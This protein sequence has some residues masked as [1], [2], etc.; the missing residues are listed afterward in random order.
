MSNSHDVF[1][2]VQSASYTRRGALKAF[3]AGIAALSLAACSQSEQSDGADQTQEQAQEEP[4]EDVTVRV[5][6]LKG[7]TTIG[8]VQMMD[9]TSGVPETDEPTTPAETGGITYSYQVIAAPDDLLPKIIQGEVDIACVPSNAGAVLYNKMNKGVRAIDINTLGILSI[10]TGDESIKEFKDLAG[11]TVY[12]SGQGATP[13][14]TFNYLA[15]SAGIADEVTLEFRSEHAEVAA[16]LAADPSAI[17]VLPQ[18]FT[19]AT[20]AK[21]ESLSSPIDLTEVW[22]QYVTDG[23]KYVVGIT[24]V[25]ADFADTHP[26]AVEDFLTRHAASVKKVNEDP[27][28]AAPLVVKAGIVAAESIAA[29]AIP[30]CNIVCETGKEMKDSLEGYLKVLYDAD[31]TSVGGALPEDDFYFGA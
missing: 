5:A 2:R 15:E 13:E 17:G 24:I 23:S 20:L 28:A 21:N 4:V 18:P 27:A 11:H 31:Q 8:L 30:A 6:S 22:E 26:E 7:P 9:E 12:I 19:T 1:N 3:G 10:V 25:N 14:Y 29:K 16:L